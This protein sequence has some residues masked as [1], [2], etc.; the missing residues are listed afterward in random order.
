[1][2]IAWLA[3]KSADRQDHAAAM[4]YADVLLRTRPQASKDVVP[5]LAQM[6]ENGTAVTE[7]KA[8]LAQNPPWRAQFFELL[9][10]SITD[11]RTPLDLLIAVKHSPVPPTTAELRSYLNFLVGRRFYALAYYTW[12]Q[13]LSPEEFSGV[14]YVFNGGFEAPPSGL[15]FDWSITTGAGTTVDID[16]VPDEE[17]NHARCP[18][19]CAGAREIPTGHNVQRD[20]S[21]PAWVKVAR[22]MRR[23]WQQGPGR[24][25]NDLRN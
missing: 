8:M 25:R 9:P 23:Q 12:L 10:N 6:A 11:A 21:W 19:D 7:L 24:E 18:A 16:T 17:G 20:A 1:M 15:P 4:H 3:G 5:L 2:A 14:G 13:F 22:H